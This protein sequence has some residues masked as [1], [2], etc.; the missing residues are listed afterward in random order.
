M[1]QKNTFSIALNKAFIFKK[2]DHNERIYFAYGSNLNLKQMAS[3]APTARPLGAAYLVGWKLVFR[4]VA[5]IVPCDNLGLL[6]IGMWRLN[7]ADED[8]LD[9]YEG[10]PKTYRK[11]EINGM[12]TYQ[13]NKGSFSEPSDRYFHTILQGYA[14]FGLDPELLYRARE[15]KY[16]DC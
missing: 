5:D 12:M 11:V 7:S 14:D 2:K 10:W 3:R 8:A 15:Q 1:N 9:K 13:M 6:P 16:Y 4:R